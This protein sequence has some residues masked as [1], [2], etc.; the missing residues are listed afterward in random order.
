MFCYKDG[1]TF[2][3]KKEEED[4]NED[5]GD[6]N[7][8]KTLQHLKSNSMNIKNIKSFDFDSDFQ[9]NQKFFRKNIPFNLK[10]KKEKELEEI[11]NIPNLIFVNDKLDTACGYTLKSVIS[12]AEYSLYN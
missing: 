9:L 4:E 6:N 1:K 5:K 10:G 11:I 8:P 7:G 3:L 2:K 12:L